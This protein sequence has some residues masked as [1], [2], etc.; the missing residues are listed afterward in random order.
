MSDKVKESI[1]EIK[2]KVFAI[3]H[4]EILLK[5]V[6]EIPTKV[7]QHKT[8][9]VGHSETGH[10]HILESERTFDVATEGLEVYMELF[11]PAKLV[12][13]KEV[14]KHDTLV[15]PAG[16]YQVVHKTEYSPFEQTIKRVQD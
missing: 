4:G 16:K 1:K 3:R 7:E 12:H 5:P 9:I 14:D 8:F 6:D 13:Q 15:V 2:M 10:H 11:A